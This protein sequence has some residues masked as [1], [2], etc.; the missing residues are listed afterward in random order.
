MDESLVDAF[1]EVVR[2][3]RTGEPIQYVLGEAEFA[4]LTFRLNGDTLIPRPETEELVL[5]VTGE[6]LPEKPRIL[7]AG[8]G[9]GCIAV[10]VA[11]ALPEA[12]VLGVDISS[13]AVAQAA[14]NARL[15]GVRVDFKT[16]DI[17]RPED[18]EWP[19]FDVIVSNPPYIHPSD[20]H[21]LNLTYEPASALTDGVDGLKA[22]EKI[23]QGAPGHLNRAGFLL[24]EHGWDQAQ[25]VR[26]LFNS[27]LWETPQTIKDLAGNDRVTM[28]R[29]RS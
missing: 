25:A 4:G 7:D 17:L 10:A 21:L 15:N 22:I 16:R 12:E 3:L 2:R 24:L 20:N 29:L 26:S 9:S 8:T 14:E 28:S 6:E 23:I 1:L 18:W 11:R 27:N 19:V 13:E 5:W